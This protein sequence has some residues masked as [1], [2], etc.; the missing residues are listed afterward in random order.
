M[1]FNLH[2]GVPVTINNGGNATLQL[3]LT[4]ILS[5]SDTTIPPA[6]TLSVTDLPVG[7]T[8][9]LT[10]SSIPHPIS[11]TV[12]LKLTAAANALASQTT[13]QVT[14][15]SGTHSSSTSILLT[16]NTPFSFVPGAPVLQIGTK[17]ES[18]SSNTTPV[19]L[20]A[21]GHVTQPLNLE[22][23]DHVKG[24]VSLAVNT[25]LPSGVTAQFNPT[26]LA[27]PKQG[28]LV[29][30]NLV[31]TAGATVAVQ[32]VSVTVVAREGGVD[33][34]AF[35]FP[36]QI[37]APF[38][39]AVAPFSGVVPEFRLPGTRVTITGGGFG[40]GTAVA[41]GLD[42]PVAASS[43]AA[44][45]TSLTAMVPATAASGPLTVKSPAGT[46]TGPSF[47]VDGY[48]NTRGYCFSN[49][50]GLTA[51]LGTTFSYEDATALFGANQTVSNFLGINMLAP[52]VRVFLGAC[53]VILGNIGFC[54][55]MC[56]T[57]LRFATRQI[58]VISFPQVTTGLGMGPA[59]PDVWTLDGPSFDAG[60]NPSPALAALIRQQ[61]MAQFSQEGI[62]NWVSFHLQVQTAAQLRNAILEGFRAGGQ[63]GVGV[64]IALSPKVGEGHVVVAFDLVDK[65]AGNFDILVYNPNI[66]FQVGE[67][68]DSSTHSS[69]L[70]ASVINAM[71]NGTW[72]LPHSD[73]IFGPGVPNWTGNIFGITVTPWDAIPQMPTFP[74]PE[75][76]ATLGVAAG[77][78]G[79]VG[80]LVGLL[81]AFAV[82]DAEIT[83]ISDGQGH[84]LLINGQ[85]NT[86]PATR[87]AG[88]RTMPALGGLGKKSIPAFVGKTQQALTYSISGKGGKSYNMTAIGHGVVA[89]LADVPISSGA[90]DVVTIDQGKVNFTPSANK[91]VALNLLGAGKTSKRPQNAVLKT[92]AS[93]GVAMNFAFDPE[94]EAFYYAHEGASANYTLE[95][96]SFDADGRATKFVSP[97]AQV[98]KGDQITFR[99]DWKQ[100]SQGGGTVSV[101]STAGGVASRLLKESR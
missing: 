23:A 86:D 21:L 51:A 42:A 73:Q 24:T 61:H 4:E 62:D 27:P 69:Q 59:G 12:T 20:V 34:S 15:A 32:T 100:L 97:A 37:V 79:A 35:T 31:L 89:T 6:V 93:A 40:P 68:T 7:V 22:I 3:T 78:I 94:A 43:V 54:F 53:D 18:I 84:K 46:A 92:T 96:S 81:M 44:D 50:K 39:S 1:A 29:V 83:Q 57:S 41:F 36:L 8:A 11:Q 9:E 63:S 80:A 65:S 64:M 82:G 13:I 49:A 48:R 26:R 19:K 88:V 38:V 76:L 60:S 16:V 72:V 98:L 91:A 75:V 17:G 87:L 30:A 85:E 70:A 58:S 47:A 99:P 2:G 14:A 74:M 66:A 56:Q 55:A 52:F 33:R 90:T 25:T 95:L 71:S 101:R 67:D 5:R 45:G 28:G 10:P 77:G